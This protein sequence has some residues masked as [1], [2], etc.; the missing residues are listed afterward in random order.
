MEKTSSFSLISVLSFEVEILQLKKNFRRDI[1]RRKRGK[2]KESSPGITQM[3]HEEQA[4]VVS[5]AKVRGW[6][7]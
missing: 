5:W 2:D 3:W 6:I 7:L 4:V 1:G